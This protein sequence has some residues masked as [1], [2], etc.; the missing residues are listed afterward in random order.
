MERSAQLLQP[1]SLS[2]VLLVLL[3]VVVVLLKTYYHPRFICASTELLEG[4][5]VRR[6]SVAER[7]KANNEMSMMRTHMA[8]KKTHER[9]KMQTLQMQRKAMIKAVGTTASALRTDSDGGDTRS[10]D[11]ADDLMLESP[12]KKRG[13]GA[14][15]SIMFRERGRGT[16]TFELFQ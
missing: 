6:L 3:V 1:T 12:Q 2:R 14:G 13:I 5:P 7:K 16:G 8:K 4:R 11:L 10:L 9:T 15:L